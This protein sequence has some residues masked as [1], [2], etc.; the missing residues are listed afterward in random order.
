VR[1]RYVFGRRVSRHRTLSRATRERRPLLSE[2]VRVGRW[3]E[4]LTETNDDFAFGPGSDWNSQARYFAYV[5]P[6][7]DFAFVCVWAQKA[8][9]GTVLVIPLG[10]SRSTANPFGQ[11]NAFPD[12][13]ACAVHAP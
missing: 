1:D 5:T 9:Q 6:V 4:L 3:T 13:P 11:S 8:K 12:D 2:R 7:S 10:Q